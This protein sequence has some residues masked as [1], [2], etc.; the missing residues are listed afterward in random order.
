VDARARQVV[1]VTGVESRLDLVARRRYAL[2]GLRVPRPAGK[3]CVETSDERAGAPLL[4]ERS[5]RR[6]RLEKP[7]Q[8]TDRVVAVVGVAKREFAVELVPVA[9]SLTRLREVA[10]FLEVGDDLR[11]ASLGDSDRGSDVSESHIWIGGD[12]RKHM[13][14]VR[15]EAPHMVVATRI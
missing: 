15:D 13:G 4:V 14:M 3:C 6:R 10:G 7:D 9:A 2:Y 12:A 5:L 8:L 11:R 1:H